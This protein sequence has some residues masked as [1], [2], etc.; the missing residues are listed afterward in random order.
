MERPSSASSI[1][2]TTESHPNMSPRGSPPLRPDPGGARHRRLLRSWRRRHH[3]AHGPSSTAHA[4]F[5][6]VPGGPALPVADRTTPSAAPAAEGLGVSS[7]RATREW[8]RRITWSSWSVG[9]PDPDPT[10]TCSARLRGVPSDKDA[11]G[12]YVGPGG[13]SRG[14]LGPETLRRPSPRRLFS[15]GVDSGSVFP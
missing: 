13:R 7:T 10:Y 2:W 14:W 11:P 12:V 6:E 15:G 1:S 9:C 3:R 5:P 8:S 4:L